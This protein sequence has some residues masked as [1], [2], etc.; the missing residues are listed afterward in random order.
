VVGLG[1]AAL[2]LY[3]P[4]NLNGGVAFTPASPRW[5]GGSA[6]GGGGAP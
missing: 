6:G 5:G 1:C 3:P 2:F 4:F